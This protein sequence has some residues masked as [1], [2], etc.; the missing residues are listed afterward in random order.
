MPEKN[1]TLLSLI[2]KS[3]TLSIFS[4]SLKKQKFD[5]KKFEQNQTTI[6]SRTL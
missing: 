2:Y 3:L 5:V 4:F 1:S 6:S